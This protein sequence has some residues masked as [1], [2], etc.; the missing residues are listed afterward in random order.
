MQTFII[1]WASS[2]LYTG[3][4]SR[5]CRLID[6]AHSVK[7]LD[8]FVCLS[9]WEKDDID[10]WY[11]LILNWNGKSL[12]L[13]PKCEIGPYFAVS[14]DAAGRIGF[15]A[16]LGAEWFA[17]RWITNTTDIVIAIKE[18]IPLVIAAEIWGKVQSVTY[19]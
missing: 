16:Y 10:W 11:H 13:F 18:M 5:V 9:S 14:S 1:D 6:H 8:H 17:E 19:K 2:P 7:H 4:R 3:H 15:G 12:F